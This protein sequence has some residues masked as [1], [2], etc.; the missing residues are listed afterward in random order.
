MAA[1]GAVTAWNGKKAGGRKTGSA[2]RITRMKANELAATGNSPLDVMINNMI[3]W[4]DHAKA[5]TEQVNSFIADM[6]TKKEEAGE[7]P[8]E[9]MLKRLE[10][11]LKDMLYAREQAQACAVDA[12]P[13]CHP[14]L[15]S[16]TLTPK[17]PAPDVAAARLGL[18][19]KEAAMEYA[20]RL[21]TTIE[22]T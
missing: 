6:R 21:R 13:Y 2:T 11:L 7:I 4:F 16:I 22:A 3:F 20:K 18:T 10:K 9:E 19:P 12:A 5:T 17:E 1:P 15:A 8:D 14:R